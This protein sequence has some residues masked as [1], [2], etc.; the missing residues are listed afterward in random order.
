[1]PKTSSGPRPVAQ[2]RRARHDYDILDTVEA[3]IVLVGSE[4]KSVREGK[5]QLRDAYARVQDG[6]VWLHGVHVAPYAY[7]S[8]FGA[9]DA[10]RSRKLLLH[11]RQIAELDQQVAKGSLTLIPL[12][13]YFKD[14]RAKVDLALARGR[15]NYDKRRAIAERDADLEARRAEARSRR[16]ES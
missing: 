16:V 13:I 4:V 11:R 10:D 6:E 9:V 3:G 7:S 5:V 14:G 15:R 12:S 1:M 2:N 8:G